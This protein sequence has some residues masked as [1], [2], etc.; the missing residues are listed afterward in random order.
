MMAQGRMMRGRHMGGQG[1]NGQAAAPGTMMPN[2]M[3]MGRNG[4]YCLRQGAPAPDSKSGAA[5]KAK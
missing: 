3:M 2:G 4:A 5:P 1:P